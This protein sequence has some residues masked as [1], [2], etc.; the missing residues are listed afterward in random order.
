MGNV[1]IEKRHEFNRENLLLQ[2][3]NVAEVLMQDGIAYPYVDGTIQTDSITGT[4]YRDFIKRSGRAIIKLK[5]ILPDGVKPITDE[6]AF[7]KGFLS[8]VKDK[9]IKFY[10]FTLRFEDGQMLMLLARQYGAETKTP[11]IN[12]NE[13]FKVTRIYL[14]GE[15]ISSQVWES[16]GDVQKALTDEFFEY[17]K[18]GE[19]IKGNHLAFSKE[20]PE[21]K[22]DDGIKKE[23][24]DVNA[25]NE[26][27]QKMI[28]ELK[29]KKQAD[30]DKKAEEA[31]QALE[32]EKK[33]QTPDVET[34]ETET[35]TPPETEE[36]APKPTDLP[37]VPEN[38]I[39]DTK[40]SL[41]TIFK[42]DNGTARGY[43]RKLFV[44][45]IAN[46]IKTRLKNGKYDEVIDTVNYIET[47]NSWSKE[48]GGKDLIG[49]RNA[50]WKMRDEAMKEKNAEVPGATDNKETESSTTE[51]ELSKIENIKNPLEM[52][53]AIS[54]LAD[55]IGDDE[56]EKHA[57]KFNELV[58][59][60]TNGI[61]DL[62][63]K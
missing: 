63:K 14:N 44:T 62:N 42:I 57:D 11:L 45:S 33:Q 40:N 7:H 59:T 61:N 39:A 37:E 10:P 30:E 6:L 3:D 46:K 15:N 19:I 34:P 47:M 36:P 50:V 58:T 24:D 25:E 5:R 32:E 16:R 26:N 38:I 41:I 56:V 52:M 22:A 4:S 17:R 35:P 12:K 29:A 28:D 21:A 2:C 8:K 27:L 13:D 1:W 60:A 43:D 31:K 23:L 20:H 18:L 51:D 54:D 53:N 48:N 9:N 49:N 55:K